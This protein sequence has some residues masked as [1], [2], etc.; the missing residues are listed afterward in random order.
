M[1][2]SDTAGMSRRRILRGTLGT[3]FATVLAGCAGGDDDDETGNGNGNGNDTG[4]GNG[5]G[6]GNGDGE[7]DE[8]DPED[9][10]EVDVTYQS[11]TDVDPTNEDGN[12]FAAD[13]WASRPPNIDLVNDPFWLAGTDQPGIFEELEKVDDSE[14]RIHLADSS[15]SNG[16]PVT[17]EDVAIFLNL[18]KLMFG[19]DPQTME[20]EGEPGAWFYGI[21]E[22]DWDGSTMIAR[23]PNEWFSEYSELELRNSV[24]YGD[25]NL[26]HNRF[27]HRDSLEE[28]LEIASDAAPNDDPYH[29]DAQSAVEEWWWDVHLQNQFE[30]PDAIVSGIFQIVEL[31]EGEWVLEKNPHHRN[32]DKVN[33]EE[34]VL[35]WREDADAQ[36]TGLQAGHADGVDQI[37]T[38]AHIVSEF[39]GNYTQSLTPGNEG[40]ALNFNHDNEWLNHQEVRQAIAV[41]LDFD[42]IAQTDHEFASQALPYPVPVSIDLQEDLDF[43][44]FFDYANT[45]ENIEWAEARLQ[46]AGF[47][48][49]GMNWYTPSD[50]PLQFELIT[51]DNTPEIE[52]QVLTQLEDFGIQGELSPLD[53]AT[54]EDRIGI[55]PE[56]Q[57]S[58]ASWSQY[59]RATENPAYLYHDWLR[60]RGYYGNET[61]YWT[62]DD[63]QEAVDAGDLEWATAEEGERAEYPEDYTA[64]DVE[65]FTVEAPPVGDFEGDLQEYPIVSMYIEGADRLDSEGQEAVLEHQRELAWVYHWDMPRIPFFETFFQGFQKQDGWVIPDEDADA[66]RL[67]PAQLLA[68]GQIQADPDA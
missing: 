61:N 42:L 65:R 50:E 54:Y 6:T 47:Y 12:F 27:Q 66:W 5:N 67:Q 24:R 36:W 13:H 2:I 58:M 4:N 39:S 34:L 53:E 48:R 62:E 41:A 43:S 23:S 64:G 1:S 30:W 17:G 32:A 29:A 20:E 10:E 56:Y 37:S 60:W 59:G 68:D 49:D 45:E 15:W 57:M 33:F 52:L 22:F 31:T 26:E 7:E 40:A 44:G 19:W 63:I 46:D 25:Y 21:E 16:E 8:I 11:F 38:P 51:D 9:L 55:P 35:E 18:H 3:A 14:F 28:G